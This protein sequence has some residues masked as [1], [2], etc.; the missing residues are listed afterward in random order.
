MYMLQFFGDLPMKAPH[1]CS[2]PM[3]YA[4]MEDA[5]NWLAD[6]VVTED[7]DG[8][9]QNK[10]WFDPEDDR[11]VIWEIE[12][13]SPAKVVW[14]ASGW[15]WQHDASDLSGGPLEQGSLPGDTMS[16]YEIAS[17]E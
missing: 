10:F 1:L 6:H 2:T 15:H 9:T 12:D 3:G 5:L 17:R 4:S 7:A 14:H 13:K 8:N 16:L 11:I